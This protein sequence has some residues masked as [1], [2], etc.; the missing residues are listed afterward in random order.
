GKFGIHVR[1]GLLITKKR[2]NPHVA[3][4]LRKARECRFDDIAS[5]A[6][7]IGWAFDS[8]INDFLRRTA[9]SAFRYTWHSS[10]TTRYQEREVV[11]IGRPC[12]IRVALESESERRIRAVRKI[13][14]PDVEAYTLRVSARIRHEIAVR[15][16]SRPIHI[17]RCT[18]R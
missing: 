15:S 18:D 14:H 6:G 1:I 11:A 5:I 9:D 12:R 16:N 8:F 10:T 13:I 3:A 4:G 17:P 2:E 7:P